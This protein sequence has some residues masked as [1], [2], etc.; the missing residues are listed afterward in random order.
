[1]MDEKQFAP[2][3][4]RN[5]EPILAV[6]REVLADY[7]AVI[8]IG[9]GTGQ[10]AVHF[11]RAMPWLTWLPTDQPGALG[12]IRAWSREAKLANLQPAREFDLFGDGQLPD[13]AD[14]LVCIN[15]L[16]I[17]AWAGCE[18]LFRC[19]SGLPAGGLVYLYGPFRYSDRPL[20]PS[21]VDFD[22]WLQARDPQSGIRDFA[23]VD[24]VARDHGFLLQ[25]DRAMPA[26]NRSLWWIKA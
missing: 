1:M 17:V 8:E 9:A 5:S 11:A 2:A 10:H 14:A 12:S 25:G 23:A 18:A 19:A 16:H 20:E 21:N 22:R 3:C 7:R 13:R 6:L 15:T 24:A 4:E 26:N